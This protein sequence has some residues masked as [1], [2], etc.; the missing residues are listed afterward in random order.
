M[1]TL[2]QMF[3]NFLI[4]IKIYLDKLKVFTEIINTLLGIHANKISED[5]AKIWKDIPLYKNFNL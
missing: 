2:K 1:I 3:N 4:S 5:N